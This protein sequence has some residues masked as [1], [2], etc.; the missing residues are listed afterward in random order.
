MDAEN[1]TPADYTI[2]VKNIPK[3]L[4][5]DYKWELTNIFQNYAVLDS[6]LELVIRKV[7]LVYD[8]EEIVEL[9][10]ELDK[11]VDKKKERIKEANYSFSDR[12]VKEVDEE[13][14]KVEKRIHHTKE[15]YVRT[16]KNF[17]G[18][19]FISFE[20]EDMKDRVLNDNRHTMTERLC[21]FVNRGR[22][23]DLTHEDLSWHEQKLFLEP[24]PEPNDVDWEFIHITT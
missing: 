1:I 21:S 22:T 10:E 7:V 18:I 5:V 23:P 17:A 3:G 15:E 9:E 8:I 14:E 11:L 24:A 6:E 4:D 12:S 16:N 13:I 2:C 19:A 20:N